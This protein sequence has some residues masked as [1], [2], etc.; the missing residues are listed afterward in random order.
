[1]RDSLG[2][3]FLTYGNEKGETIIR[4]MPYLDNPQKLAVA[5]KAV[6]NKICPSRNGKFLVTGCSDG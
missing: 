2:F 5:K 3:E 6:V 4:A 1:L